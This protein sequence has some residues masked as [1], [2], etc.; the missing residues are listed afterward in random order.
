MADICVLMMDRMD[1]ENIFWMLAIIVEVLFPD[2]YQDSMEGFHTDC[3]LIGFFLEQKDAEL[4][5]HL[6]S[7]LTIFSPRVLSHSYS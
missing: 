5:R 2:Y 6:T 3:Q 4:N 7:T 1:E